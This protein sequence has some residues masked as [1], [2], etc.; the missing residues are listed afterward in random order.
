MTYIKKKNMERIAGEVRFIKDQ[1]GNSTEW[2]WGG[3]SPS[4]RM[5]DKSHA[6]NPKCKKAL[7]KVMRSSLFALGHA[8]SAYSRFSKIK[9][10]DI[11]PDGR[12]GGRGYI[13]E[14]KT[15]RKQYMN[16]VEALS[17]LSDTI[18]DEINADHWTI[19]REKII[20]EYMNEAQQIM[21]DPEE[22]AEEI[23][24]KGEEK[25]ER[26]IYAPRSKQASVSNI[27]SR[28]MMEKK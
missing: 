25:L 17:S 12:L 27:V 4:E 1:G 15:M 14:I 26:Q 24:E 28:Y 18:Y 2:A 9:S 3:Y 20:E 6:F 16:V 21:E 10:R 8:M 5:M 23:E 13:Q 19:A 22:W 11:S 7:A